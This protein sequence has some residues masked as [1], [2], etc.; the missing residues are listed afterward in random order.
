MHENTVVGSNLLY[1][2]CWLF[3]TDFIS[4]VNH[5]HHRSMSV[6]NKA[7]QWNVLQWTVLWLF[8][9]GDIRKCKTCTHQSSRRT[10]GDKENKH[11]SQDV[12]LLRQTMCQTQGLQAESSLTRLL[13]WPAGA[14]K[15]YNLC[16]TILCCGM[17]ARCPLTT[18][19][20]MHPNF[21]IQALKVYIH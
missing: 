6:S 16:N 15:E 21:V 5:H 9:Q 8:K 17:E 12:K 14:Y 13:L 2:G 18:C 1:P 7:H 3:W 19:P 4:T 20:R 11:I 10:L